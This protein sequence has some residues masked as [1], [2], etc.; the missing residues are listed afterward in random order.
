VFGGLVA[1]ALPL[2][3]GV[4]SVLGT[5]FTLF[6][7]TQFT[8][9]SIFS[10]N[11]VTALGLGLAID[12]SLFIVSRY[13]E[14]LAR[15]RTVEQAVI[16]TVETAGR[17]VAVSAITVAVSLSALLVFPLYFLRSFAY[18]GIGVTLVS[19]ISSILTLP[20]LL[21]VLGHRVNSLKVFGRTPRPVNPDGGFWHRVAMF[22]MRRPVAIA[23]T[24]IAVLVL[25]GL[26]FLHVNFGVPDQR[27]LPADSPAR[28]V[29]DRLATEF[30]SAE[31]SAFPVVATAA[32]D[33][34]DES[35]SSFAQTMSS[36]PGVARVDAP[37]GRY[38]AGALLIGPDPSLDAFRSTVAPDGTETTSPTAVR[39]SVVPSVEP[40]STA[41]EQLVTDIRRLDASS[42]GGVQV[43]GASA[44]LVDSKAAIGD[45]LPLAAGI[46]ALSTFVL[47]F[48]MFGSVV[49]PLKAIVLNL[50]SLTATFGAMV[51]IFQEGHLSSLLGFTPTGLT[52]T[53]T[54]I[55]M[56]CIAFGLSMDYEVFLLS[57]IKEEHDRTGDNTA[58]VAAGLEK[59]G[60]IVTAAAGL[61]AITFI[62]FSTSGISFI[63]LFG[64][65]LTLAVLMDATLVRAFLVPAFMKLAGEANWWAP[66]WMQAIHR[67]I[68]FSES[69]PDDDDDIEDSGGCGSGEGPE[70]MRYATEDEIALAR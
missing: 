52:D 2:A 34:T 61:L 25:L 29:S 68:G 35:I 66:R 31:A 64:L 13:R 8:D 40:I 24:V 17:T 46:I 54:P 33:A 65:G 38:A 51:W 4:V 27:V 58:S 63:K 19:V 70:S 59:T 16:R 20:A 62:A 56:F 7:V 23:T 36:L 49:V 44:A 42:I 60:R 26:P 37:T 9:V 48:L 67:R 43:G 12:Y 47:L 21:A 5:F 22:V 45:K 18:A 30:T 14:E 69:G 1:A 55:L 10:I 32:T 15:G 28:A 11:L 3:V 39:F 57:R 50:L 53:T 41:G 6:V